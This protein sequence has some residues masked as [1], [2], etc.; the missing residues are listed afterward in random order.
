M[1]MTTWSTPL[2]DSDASVRMPASFRPSSTRSLGHL[3]RTGAPVTRRM[4]RRRRPPP[5]GS[6]AAGP[7]ASPPAATAPRGTGPAPPA[8]QSSGPCGPGPPSAAGDHRRAAGRALGR[9]TLAHGV[10]GVHR[11][12]VENLWLLHPYCLPSFF[13]MVTW[14]SPDVKSPI[15]QRGATSCAAPCFPKV[16][17][18]GCLIP[19]TQTTRFPPGGY[20]RPPAHAGGADT[21][22]RQST[23]PR[24]GI[25]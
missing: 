18:G 9:Q 20:R 17:A 5:W 10:G 19:I 14:I 4:A 15:A 2:P 25:F 23:W 12:I 3:I 22:G 6:G 13:P 24:R 8:I 7:P 16:K 1:P 11:V 21:P